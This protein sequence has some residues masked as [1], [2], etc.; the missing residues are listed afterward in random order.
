M[1]WLLKRT[2][3]QCLLIKWMEPSNWGLIEG[4]R[5]PSPQQR[6][7]PMYLPL[8]CIFKKTFIHLSLVKC[9]LSL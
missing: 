8:H 1:K 5:P 4:F 6:Q 3:L 9:A 2:L 7:A